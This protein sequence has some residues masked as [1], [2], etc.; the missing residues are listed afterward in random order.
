MWAGHE[1]SL[2]GVRFV[3]AHHFLR[4]KVGAIVRPDCDFAHADGSFTIRC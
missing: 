1:T 4:S 2:G 3:G